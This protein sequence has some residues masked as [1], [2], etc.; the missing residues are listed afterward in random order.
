MAAGRAQRMAEVQRETRQAVA[1]VG[2]MWHGRNSDFPRVA[3]LAKHWA[4][5]TLHGGG[6]AQTKHCKCPFSSGQT[7]IYPVKSSLR[8][9]HTMTEGG[10][11]LNLFL[12]LF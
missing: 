3:G 6:K 10:I 8:A 5:H 12:H 11:L 2:G 4:D 1:R 7:N 9:M